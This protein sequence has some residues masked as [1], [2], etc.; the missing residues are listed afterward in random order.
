MNRAP[1]ECEIIVFPLSRQIGKAR[2]LAELMIPLQIQEERKRAHGYYVRQVERFDAQ[3]IAAGYSIER[4]GTELEA[5]NETLNIETGR[6]VV[7]LSK[8]RK[9]EQQAEREKMRE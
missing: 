8:K 3:M 1:S 5:F 4:R 7:S 2:R 6:F 9:S